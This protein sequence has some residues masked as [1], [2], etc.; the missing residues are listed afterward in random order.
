MVQAT[1]EINC[2]ESRILTLLIHHSQDMRPNAG[3][4][5]QDRD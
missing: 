5:V 4:G 2:E 3:Y 1:T